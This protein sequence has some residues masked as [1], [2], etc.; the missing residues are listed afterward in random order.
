MTPDFVCAMC[1]RRVSEMS[2]ACA[3]CDRKPDE[4][5]T[6]AEARVKPLLR[7][8]AA[9]LMSTHIY[10]PYERALVEQ[11]LASYG[12]DPGGLTSDAKAA[13]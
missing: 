2:G 5:R 4:V 13:R 1:S 3:M 10:A 6:E 12:L 11:E 8:R 9:L 7:L